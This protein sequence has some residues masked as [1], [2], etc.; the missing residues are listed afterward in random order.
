MFRDKPTTNRAAGWFLAV[1][2]AI[3]G[4]VPPRSSRVL[5]QA[6]DDRDWSRL[7]TAVAFVAWC[8]AWLRLQRHIGSPITVSG[9]LGDRDILTT[10]N[11]VP[12]TLWTVS[13]WLMATLLAI[14]ATQS[15]TTKRD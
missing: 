10:I 8:I 9:A 6:R 11:I 5:V 15:L 7:L 4:S 2:P 3:A 14:M 1:Y 12:D 13:L